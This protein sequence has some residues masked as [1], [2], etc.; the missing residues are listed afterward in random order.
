VT[1]R[2]VAYILAI[3]KKDIF[4]EHFNFHPF[5]VMICGKCEIV[6]HGI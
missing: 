5:G 1:Y 6:V 3:Q 2:L 4:M